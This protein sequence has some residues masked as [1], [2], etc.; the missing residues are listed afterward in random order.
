VG[1]R[2]RSFSDGV[3]RPVGQF[4]EDDGERIDGV[5]LRPEEDGADTPVIVEQAIYP[6][7]FGRAGGVPN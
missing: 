5:W 7:A 3:T 6:Q 2:P 4:I 1:W